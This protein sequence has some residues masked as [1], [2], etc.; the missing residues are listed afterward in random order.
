MN[1][2]VF[3]ILLGLFLIVSSQA[4]AQETPQ[5]KQA[6]TKRTNSYI[7]K[8]DEFLKLNEDQKKQLTDMYAS[9]PSTASGKEVME[10]VTA[11]LKEILTPE[12]YNAYTRKLR[13]PERSN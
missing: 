11:R 12:Q 10:T 7:Q 13:G 2:T 3:T 5:Q 8:L 6:K 4:I 9:I 1:K